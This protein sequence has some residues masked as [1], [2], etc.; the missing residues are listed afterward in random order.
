MQD[1][2]VLY[3]QLAPGFSGTA[4]LYWTPAE[5]K[6]LMQCIARHTSAS[7]AEGRGWSWKE[8]SIVVG[9]PAN[10]CRARAEL[11]GDLAAGLRTATIGPGKGGTGI[12]TTRMPLAEAS[13]NPVLDAKLCSA[14]AMR[15]ARENDRSGNHVVNGWPEISKLV[16]K[17]ISSCRHRLQCLFT[18]TAVGTDK[19][20]LQCTLCR[21][22]FK[23]YRNML[24]HNSCGKQRDCASKRGYW[25]CK[26]CCRPFHHK[27]GFISH[28]RTCKGPASTPALT[29]DEEQSG[30]KSRRVSGGPASPSAAANVDQPPSLKVVS[31]S[32]FS[33]KEVEKK[34]RKRTWQCS[35]SEE[36]RLSKVRTH[37]FV[38][39]GLIATMLSL[40]CD[41]VAW[42]S[43]ANVS[44][45]Y[46]C[47]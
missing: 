13:W 17:S 2:T 14:A 26:K 33:S 47:A 44:D 11:L 45:S 35:V 28:C 20:Q 38:L 21:V 42:L 25:L 3:P 15:V 1:T 10:S 30:I 18:I 19:E 40:T 9:H 29:S 23:T 27:S 34:M 43:V 8:T 12:D 37:A 22:N 41:L 5:D 39:C 31:T 16:G 6:K 4:S 36:A 46:R 32:F 24:L 7:V